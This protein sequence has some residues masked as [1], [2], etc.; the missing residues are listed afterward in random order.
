MKDWILQNESTLRVIAFTGVFFVI[1][2]W[3]WLS[4]KRKRLQSLTARWVN[5]L[6]LVVINTLLVRLLFPMAAVGIALIVSEQQIGLLNLI[7]IHPIA[8]VTLSVI[9]LDC[10]IY[11]QHRLMHTVPL[12]WR[13]HR[14]HH[15]DPEFDV[16]TGLRFHPL[17]IIISMIYKTLIIALLGAPVLAVLIFELLLNAGSLFNHGN[18]NLNAKL[19]NALRR[20]IVTPDMHRIHH[21]TDN[22]ESNRNFGFALSWWDYLFSSYQKTPSLA[23][24]KMHIGLDEYRNEKDAI[25]L[26][27]VLSIP[28][29][30]AHK[31]ARDQRGLSK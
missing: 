21:S 28:F 16:T 29:I 30:S 14:V 5:N 6:A 1:A 4:P 12:L 2:L 9:L 19:D 22:I 25:F 7:E 11:W 13:M 17:E 23:H 27:G 24:E 18:I 31:K 8:A 15:A 26:P 10:A 20:I 3:E